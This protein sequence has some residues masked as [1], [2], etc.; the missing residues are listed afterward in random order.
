MT[1]KQ[2]WSNLTALQVGKYAEYLIKM[3]FSLSGFEVYS[4]E[5]D[6]H[7]VDLIARRKGSKTFLEI[8]VKSVRKGSGYIFIPEEKLKPLISTK[9][10]SVVLFEDL[11]KPRTYLVPSTSWNKPNDL[12]VYRD[13]NGKKSKPEF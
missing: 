10:V 11:E 13:Y 12:F 4:P 3:E 6:D 1:E 5:I 7:G 2:I 8:Q 9:L